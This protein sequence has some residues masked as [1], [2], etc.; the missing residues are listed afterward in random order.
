ML[1]HDNVCKKHRD[2]QN[3]CSICLQNISKRS[4]KVLGC[5]H[6]FHTKC[7][8][9]WCERTPCCPICRADILEY[10]KEYYIEFE[11]SVNKETATYSTTLPNMDREMH[12]ELASYIILKCAY[13]SSWLTYEDVVDVNIL[14]IKPIG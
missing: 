13:E 4:E 14:E 8:K 9:R 10:T 12:N 11:L 5:G 3:E 6:S 7:I 2:D 1:R